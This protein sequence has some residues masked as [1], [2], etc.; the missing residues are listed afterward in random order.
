MLPLGIS[1]RPRFDEEAEESQSIYAGD[2]V[3]DVG[4]VMP[5]NSD[6]PSLAS[7]VCLQGVAVLPCVLLLGCSRPISVMV[8]ACS[9]TGLETQVQMRL[10]RSIG[11]S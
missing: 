8:G 7:D 1:T 9:E 4:K 10:S 6:S 3:Q 11:M 5:G 2:D